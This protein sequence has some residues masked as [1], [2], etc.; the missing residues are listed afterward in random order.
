MLYVAFGVVPSLW[1]VDPDKDYTRWLECNQFAMGLLAL[2]SIHSDSD[3]SRLWT[4]C[5]VSCFGNRG[6][7]PK[8]K[9]SPK[10]KAGI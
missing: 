7:L 10:L 8:K 5:P 9:K 3:P 1:N 2:L 4:T 6:L